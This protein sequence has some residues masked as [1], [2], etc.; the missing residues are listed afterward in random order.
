ML[1]A[2][3]EFRSFG[4]LPLNKEP[5]GVNLL[6]FSESDWMQYGVAMRFGVHSVV[7]T[8]LSRPSHY[9]EDRFG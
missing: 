1:R 8:L 6:R 7:L 5:H 3:R 2:W 4:L 9:E